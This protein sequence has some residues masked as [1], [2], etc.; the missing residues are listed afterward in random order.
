MSPRQRRLRIALVLLAPLLGL[1]LAEFLARTRPPVPSPRL[2]GGVHQDVGHPEQLF[3]NRP[4]ARLVVDYELPG[5]RWRVVHE[6]N[7]AGLRGPLPLEPRSQDVPRIVCL[8]DS[9]T[10]GHGVEAQAAWP[11][12]LAERLGERGANVEV[13]NAGV[14]G[15]D[16][17]QTVV[18]LQRR[19]LDLEPD[20]V[21]LQ[22]H[23]NDAAC[24]GQGPREEA[25]DGLLTWTDPERGPRFLQ[26]L[27]GASRAIDAVLAW[28]HARRQ[29]HAYGRS[30]GSLYREDA[31]G[32]QRA[33]AA[34][35]RM[36]GMLRARGVPFGV[37]LF[38]TLL[39]APGGL[40]SDEA[41]AHW[42]A[43]LEEAR[44]PCLDAGEAL[45]RAA[46]SDLASWRVHP[47]DFHANER[48]HDRFAAEVGTWLG[49]TAELR[50]ALPDPG[51][52]P[53]AAAPWAAGTGLAR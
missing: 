41:F 5:R 4:G 44:I 7:A 29:V 18:W 23:M 36:R 1:G 21:L 38:P 11:A 42:R 30:L 37:V 45:T 27:R 39:P 31:E 20:L 10:F 15:Y 35:L 25:R 22:V 33:R 8:G 19:I 53:A 3:E 46:G 2:Q 47:H 28:V 50:P 13:L 43:F 48:A 16:P 24:R 40:V 9:H 12:R 34:V 6:V 52:E 14:D 51:R 17:T 26:R 49:R 32:W